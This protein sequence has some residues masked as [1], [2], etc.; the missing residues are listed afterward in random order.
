MPSPA[1]TVKLLASD[2]ATLAPEDIA[3]GIVGAEELRSWEP[4]RE[5]RFVRAFDELPQDPSSPA[6]DTA[7]ELGCKQK[8][9]RGQAKRRA[10]RAKQLSDLPETED[11][12]ENG[13]ITDAHAGRPRPRPRARPDAS[14][15]GRARGRRGPAAG[16][17]H[18]R[19]PTSFSC[20][21]TASSKSTARTT[22]SAS[23][24][25]RRAAGAFSF[26]RDKDGHDPAAGHVRPRVRA[27]FIRSTIERVAEELFR[28]GSSQP[29]GRRAGA[30]GRA[31]QRAAQR[32]RPLTEV[33]RRADQVDGPAKRQ[34]PRGR[35]PSATRISWI[36]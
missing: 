22:A 13:S 27:R 3:A 31:D 20:G 15:T 1:Q 19:R 16:T 23:G 25:G 5:G 34:E 24:P 21:S 26:W 30:V 17:R 10:E 32:R 18:S 4:A 28:T 2:P 12:L 35:L 36:A 33:C 8:V 11:T 29:S 9:G 6:K 7:E 14:P